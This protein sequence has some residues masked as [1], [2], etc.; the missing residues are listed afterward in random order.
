[1][2]PGEQHGNSS[3]ECGYGKLMEEKITEFC[4]VGHSLGVVPVL[5]D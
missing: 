5:D 2:K 3:K 4:S 1:M